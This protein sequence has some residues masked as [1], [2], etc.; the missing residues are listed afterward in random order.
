MLSE[1]PPKVTLSRENAESKTHLQ[2]NHALDIQPDVRFSPHPALHGFMPLVRVILVRCSS[3]AWGFERPGSDTEQS[4]SIVAGTS[5]LCRHEFA[6][7]TDGDDGDFPNSARRAV[8]AA[9]R[10]SSTM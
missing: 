5:R 3:M 4:G 6:S 2:H 7:W 10:R 9:S 8:F 1:S